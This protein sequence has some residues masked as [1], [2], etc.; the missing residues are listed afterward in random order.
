MKASIRFWRCQL[1]K[2]AALQTPTRPAMGPKNGARAAA[3]ISHSATTTAATY[4]K[5]SPAVRSSPVA[6]RRSWIVRPSR[7]RRS[8][9]STAAKRRAR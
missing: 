5:N 8:R 1:R 9:R 3:A 2:I 4:V 6:D 7:V